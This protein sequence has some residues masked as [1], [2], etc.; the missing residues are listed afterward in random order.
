MNEIVVIGK[1]LAIG[2]DVG[3]FV[4]SAAGGR[5]FSLGTNLPAVPV[6]D[7]RHHAGTKTLTAATFGH[8]IQRVELPRLP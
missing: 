4:S 2:T 8:G 7:L 5:W 6:F 3:V 1:S